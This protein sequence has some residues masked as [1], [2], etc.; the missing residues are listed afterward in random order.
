MNMFD[1]LVLP[2]RTTRSWKEQFGRV[3]IEAMACETPVVGS[4]SGEIPKVIGDAGLIFPE[5]DVVTLAHILGCVHDTAELGTQLGKKGRGRVLEM[6]THRRIAEETVRL[7]RELLGTRSTRAPV[8]RLE[9]A[10]PN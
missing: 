3:L 6:F 4:S 10:H 2:S 1:V 8:G 9:M 5:G 7:Y